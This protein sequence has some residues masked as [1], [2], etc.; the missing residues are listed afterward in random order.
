MSELIKSKGTRSEELADQQSPHPDMIWISGGTFRMGSEDFYPEERPVHEVAVTG[1]WMDRY[2]VT[3][4]QFARFVE[5]TGYV[6][7]AERA[8]NP[9]DFPGAPAEN[10]VPGSMVFQ[11]TR[12]PVDLRN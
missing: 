12:G 5:V 3:N 1:F 7:V 9:D 11:K 8:L 10:L 6:T 2:A 4:D